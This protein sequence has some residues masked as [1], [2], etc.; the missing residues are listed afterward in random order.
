M[1]M[2]TEFPKLTEAAKH[3][4]VKYLDL[5]ICPRLWYLKRWVTLGREE[6]MWQSAVSP[7][8]STE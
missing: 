3:C 8:S 7:G 2:V 4:S 5:N 6:S 1:S